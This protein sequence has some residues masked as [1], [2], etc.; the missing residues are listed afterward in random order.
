[1]ARFGTFFSLFLSSPWNNCFNEHLCKHFVM[2]LPVFGFCWIFQTIRYEY[3]G[4]R[5]CESECEWS[6]ASQSAND[7]I[8]NKTQINAVTM[9]CSHK[10]NYIQRSTKSKLAHSHKVCKCEFV[11]V[12]FMVAFATWLI[13]MDYKKNLAQNSTAFYDTHTKRERR[14]EYAG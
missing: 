9:K 14:R 12:F 11:C 2:N 4:A 1:M 8:K 13:N 6:A 5:V 10:I 3:M 7:K